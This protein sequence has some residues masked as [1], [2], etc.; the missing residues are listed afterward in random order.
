VPHIFNIHSQIVHPTLCADVKGSNIYMDLGT[1]DRQAVADFLGKNPSSTYEPRVE[2]SLSSDPI[3]TV[4]SQPLP[5]L[6][7]FDPETIQVYLGDFGEGPSI[8]IVMGDQP[9]EVLSSAVPVEEEV[10]WSVLIP[11]PTALRAPEVILGH[12]WGTAVD[13]WA[14]GCL[15]RYDLDFFFDFHSTYVQLLEMLTGTWGKIFDLDTPAAMTP[16]QVHLARME[17]LLG[18][19]PHAFLERCSKREEFFDTNGMSSLQHSI[20]PMIS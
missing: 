1:S 16:T 11:M 19:F 7:S 13:V 17:E 6:R 18:P 10:R 9:T 20:R 15:V 2:P 3:V 5:V 8:S 14:T 12:S 4:R